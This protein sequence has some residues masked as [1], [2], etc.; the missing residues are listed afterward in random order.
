MT[1]SDLRQHIIFNTTAGAEGTV[2]DVGG[3]MAVSVSKDA[4]ADELRDLIAQNR[5]GI[6]ANTNPLDGKPH[7]FIELGGWLGD[8]GLALH[9]MALAEATGLVKLFDEA[10]V[11]VERE[12][13]NRMTQ[14]GPA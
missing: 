3:V 14:S 10:P 11:I 1:M 5:G 4:S 7:D 9:F 2:I 6:Y 12:T 13:W 8:Q